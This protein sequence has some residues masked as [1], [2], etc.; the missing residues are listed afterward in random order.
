VS[1]RPLLWLALASVLVAGLAAFLAGKPRSESGLSGQRV[2]P[3]LESKLNAVT[4]LRL[5]KGDGERVTLRKGKTDWRVAERGYPADAGRIR[6]LL[7]D[8]A[9]LEVQE[10]K[11]RTAANYPKLG[12]EDVAPDATGTLLEVIAPNQSYT[13]II[14]KPAGTKASYVRVPKNEQSLQAQPQVNV[15]ADPKRWIDR[16]LIDLPRERVRE[17]RVQTPGAESYS[18][19]RTT[20]EQTDF[21]VQG[22]PKGRELTMP[23]VGNAAASALTSLNLDDVR[24]AARPAQSERGRATATFVT[25]DG[26]AIEV[27]GHKE[28]ERHYLSGTAKSTAKET[29]AEAERLNAK[30]AAWEF[31]IPAYKYETIFKPLEDML[32]EKQS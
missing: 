30:L 32:V 16:T 2:L 14:G 29:A 7:L 5:S 20:K 13:L 17:V 1:R 24:R 19:S 26:L 21:A 31:E 3:G 22:I 15:D 9:A 25:F 23:T 10:E 12:V 18:V 8:L 28:G 6:K 4:E 11:T 27:T